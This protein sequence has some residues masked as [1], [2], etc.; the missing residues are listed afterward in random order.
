MQDTN[1][2]ADKCA[3]TQSMCFFKKKEKN[4]IILNIE[5]CCVVFMNNRTI[6]TQRISNIFELFG[7]SGR[8]YFIIL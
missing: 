4:S 1:R 7:I 3:T 8:K 2:V 5:M 6:N